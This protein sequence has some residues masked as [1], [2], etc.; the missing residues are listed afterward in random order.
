VA[1]GIATVWQ[2][3]AVANWLLLEMAS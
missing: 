1:V 2:G 3:D